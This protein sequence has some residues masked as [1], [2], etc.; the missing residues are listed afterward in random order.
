MSTSRARLTP[1]AAA[2]LVAAGCSTGPTPSPR[3][4]AFFASLL[5]KPA[6]PGTRTKGGAPETEAP[7]AE[8]R[9]GASRGG[10]GVALASRRTAGGGPTGPA[11]APSAG[12]YVEGALRAQGIVFGTDGRPE[13]LY[14]YMRHSQRL[15]APEKVRAGDVL[16]FDLGRGCGTHVG[17]VELVDTRGR[18]SFRE[19]RDGRVRSSFVHPRERTARRDA[20]GQVLNTFLRPKRIDDPPET[21]YFA[22]E[23]LCA[24]GRVHR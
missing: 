13:S 6:D 19:S 1:I 16:F 2:I 24:V 23:L 9:P 10:G 17:L 11:E 8:A 4:R 21:R 5:D 18:V 3:S 20:S 7:R 22:G 15:V 12:E 14:A